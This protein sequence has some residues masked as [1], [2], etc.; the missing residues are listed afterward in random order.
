MLRHFEL[1]ILRAFN[2]V[3]MFFHVPKLLPGFGRVQ[4]GRYGSYDYAMTQPLL[5]TPPRWPESSPW[6]PAC[7][8]SFPL[9]VYQQVAGRMSFK[10]PT[11]WG[12]DGYRVNK[13]EHHWRG[14][15][16]GIQQF[17]LC[18]C[19]IFDD[20][21]HRRGLAGRGQT[22]VRTGKG[23]VNVACEFTPEIEP[24]DVPSGPSVT[25]SNNLGGAKR[26]MM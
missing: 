14:N 15:M 2:V 16:V 11:L 4:L 26:L 1:R 8:A 9:R 6:W 10:L 25:V 18:G 24:L 13:N 3:V 21:W 5:P 23:W 19:L 17:F 22:T 12:E 20:N 7:Q